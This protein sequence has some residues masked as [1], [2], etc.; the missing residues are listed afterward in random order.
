MTFKIA[1]IHDNLYEGRRAMPCHNL[2]TAQHFIQPGKLDESDVA[3]WPQL[4]IE[5]WNFLV[6][7]EEDN[8]N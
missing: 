7:V 3:G 2:A 8:Y 6:I 4:P 1:T 5:K